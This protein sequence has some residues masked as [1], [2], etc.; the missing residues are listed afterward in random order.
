MKPTY[1]ELAAQVEVLRQKGRLLVE[2]AERA[3][4]FD[5]GNYHALKGSAYALDNALDATPAACL[6]HVKADAGRA[7]FVEGAVCAR[8][9]IKPNAV[10]IKQSADQY[11]EHIRRG[12]A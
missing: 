12:E 2:Q 6:A 8:H 5:I 7:G 10:E 1:E 3:L 9:P 11:A 4:D